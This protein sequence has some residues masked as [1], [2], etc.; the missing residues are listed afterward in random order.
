M[1]PANIIPP[2]I[3]IEG[4][5]GDLPPGASLGL[6]VRL[7]GHGS[8]HI[9]DQVLVR[10]I[11]T[12]YED[13]SR[14]IRTS[15]SECVILEGAHLTA[16]GTL[17][18]D[19]QVQIP[20]DA[21]A[22]GERSIYF[23]EVFADIAKIEDPRARLDIRV[24]SE[25]QE[26]IESSGVSV[27]I[28]DAP[29]AG[30]PGRP[31][32]GTVCV[33]GG[34]RTFVLQD[35]EC[36]L[37]LLNGVPGHERSATLA[38]L[39]LLG[40]PTSLEP[41]YDLRFRF[42]LQL[43]WKAKAS[44]AENRYS[45]V[46]S[47]TFAR[48]GTCECSK[49]LTLLPSRGAFYRITWLQRYAVPGISGIAA[50]VTSCMGSYVALPMLAIAGI[51][52]AWIDGREA[53]PQTAA[54]LRDGPPTRDTTDGP[55]GQDGPPAGLLSRVPKVL[56]SLLGSS[57]VVASGLLAFG[58]LSTSAL[59]GFVG[60]P[61]LNYDYALLVEDGASS[62]LDTVGI[63]FESP[64]RMGV[65]LAVVLSLSLTWLLEERIAG[66]RRALN[67]PALLLTTH[68][69]VTF[70]SLMV[71]LAMVSI[72]RLANGPQEGLGTSPPRAAVVG[73]LAPEKTSGH[74]ALNHVDVAGPIGA[75]LAN[76]DRI[77]EFVAPPRR[78]E[79]IPEIASSAES[80]Y[81]TRLS[82]AHRH[83]SEALFARLCTIIA[84]LV[85]TETAIF[86]WRRRFT[87][88]AHLGSRSDLR[89]TPERMSAIS[90][91]VLGILSFVA[92]MGA[93]FLIPVAHGILARPF[94]GHEPVVLLL[95]RT[96]ECMST[97]VEMGHRKETEP[98]HEVPFT[99]ICTASSETEMLDQATNFEAA[100]FDLLTTR[101]DELEAGELLDGYKTAVDRL[102]AAVDSAHCIG[103]VE[104][105]W[106]LR[107][108]PAVHELNE[109]AAEYYWRRAREFVNSRT[110]LRFGNIL[111]LPRQ[112]G[113]H[114]TLFSTMRRRTRG[115]EG[116]WIL[117]D[118]RRD[119]VEDLVVTED[120][121]NRYDLPVDSLRDTDLARLSND[122]SPRALQAA[123]RYLRDPR[124]P[125]SRRG[126]MITLAG[127]MA[128][129][130]YNHESTLTTIAIHD[131]I[132]IALG[133][134]PASAGWSSSEWLSREWFA[135]LRSAG[136]TIQFS[137]EERG[138]AITS[139]HMIGG[140]YAAVRIAQCLS[141]YPESGK[142]I[143]GTRL[144]VRDALGRLST[145]ITTSGFLLADLHRA[146]VEPG[147][148]AASAVDASRRAL[149]DVLR[150]SLE[151]RRQDE[152]EEQW[153]SRAGAACTI[154]PVSRSAQMEP[155]LLSAADDLLEAGASK[156]AGACI[157]ALGRTPT[158]ASRKALERLQSGHHPLPETALS[159]AKGLLDAEHSS[160]G[161]DSV[162]NLALQARE[163][164]G[165]RTRP[166]GERAGALEL[167]FLVDAKRETPTFWN[168][169]TE[170]KG[171]ASATAAFFLKDLEQPPLVDQILDCLQGPDVSAADRAW[172]G[173]GIALGKPT[174]A[175]ASRLTAHLPAP[176]LDAQ[177]L[178]YW[179]AAAAELQALG[180][181][182][183]EYGCATQPLTREDRWKEATKLAL[184]ALLERATDE[185][186][187]L[188][189]ENLTRMLGD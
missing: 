11:H 125:P 172:C 7:R 120:G 151:T 175:H 97:H 44:D 54:P 155:L 57:A 141:T 178:A 89:F 23:V 146:P 88:T 51:S 157:I 129:I 144:D 40:E 162:P 134:S 36:R 171:A 27:T 147:S 165:D 83:S 152:S 16:D 43:P 126:A 38:T 6:T 111:S 69:A 10:L 33:R 17:T 22:S 179:C 71:A 108:R 160:G 122:T 67:K 55:D 189:L 65:I 140:P 63:I 56:A 96:P 28:A 73:D 127:V 94:V 85:L 13:P 110:Y 117:T 154:I 18:A 48:L 84:I 8:P 75:M 78:T 131:L 50:A 182:V 142:C 102:V 103:A 163:I 123:L 145:I 1:T 156:E 92:T 64:W 187:D 14:E 77:H 25:P 109:D 24:V 62:L 87:Q 93:V 186:D 168:V 116:R 74:V 53:Q 98:P 136:A 42:Y 32:S 183:P 167:L 35:V 135:G 81:P 148:P 41:R 26:T 188:A 60:L 177:V 30:R 124:T 79:G 138:A 15:I 119:C 58:F 174:P 99:H 91:R 170:R 61:M 90:G 173:L 118:I 37:L 82:E 184:T 159:F 143:A 121:G 158:T 112:R 166:D 20:P 115:T 39:I 128:R 137:D 4:T 52:W 176:P 169:F 95:K 107:P 180:A 49:P 59:Y 101:N 164:A 181:T 34:H 105:L 113:E 9:I 161:G 114:I 130:Y 133:K 12:T 100:Y 46:A 72:A 132:N 185:K 150:Q 106:E 47:A 3:H 29:G 104:R 139:L 70:T 153:R 19:T 21:Q 86:V 68:T 2:S 80:G 149:E 76:F 45:L 66:L 31:L 5:T